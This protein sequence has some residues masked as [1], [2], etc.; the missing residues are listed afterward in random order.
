MMPDTSVGIIPV[1]NLYSITNQ[2]AIRALF[3]VINRHVGNLPPMPGVFPGYPA[4]VIRNASTERELTMIRWACRH[5]RSP[6]AHRLPTLGT[7]ERCIHLNDLNWHEMAPI[8]VAISFP[9]A[10]HTC[11]HKLP[12]RLPILASQYR[13]DCDLLCQA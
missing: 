10:V 3:R 2:E 5:R 8:L 6:A 11:C 1:C 7:S 12:L 9:T 13:L 4:P